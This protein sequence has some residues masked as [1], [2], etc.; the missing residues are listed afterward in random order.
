MKS[1]I[2]TYTFMFNIAVIILF[3]IIYNLIPQNNFEPL[4]PHDK[5]TYLDFVFYA[6]TIQSGIGLS[7]VNAISN[8]AKFLAIIQQLS[9]MG[10]AFILLTFIVNK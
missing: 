3:S 2:V 4:H 10:S 1:N 5:L 7:D 6:V 9:L 8:L